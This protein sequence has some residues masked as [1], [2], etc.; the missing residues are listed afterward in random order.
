M[1]SETKGQPQGGTRHGHQ[2]E[3]SESTLLVSI[4]GISFVQLEYLKRILND[5]ARFPS[6]VDIQP[7]SFQ[8]NVAKLQF[9]ITNSSQEFVDHLATYDFGKFSLNVLSFA[10]RKID[11]VLKM[12]S[13]Q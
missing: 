4:G 6:L 7:K 13:S 2:F 9:T 10:P 12:K 11:L 3:T 8:S 1:A 5:Q